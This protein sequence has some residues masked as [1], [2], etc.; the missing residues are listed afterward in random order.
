MNI[1]N[2]VSAHTGNDLVEHGMETADWIIG[3]VLIIL[4]IGGIYLF[5]KYNKK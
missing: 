1:I 4:I 5:K 3:F 2:L